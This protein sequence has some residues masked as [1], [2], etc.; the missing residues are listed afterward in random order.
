LALPADREWRQNWE[1]PL[2]AESD[3]ASIN[4][5]EL[6]KSPKSPFSVIP[7]KAGIQFLR[8]LTECLDAG[9]HRGDGFLRSYQL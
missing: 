8:A 9:F 4:L 6:V 7:A 2:A 5:D 1:L 3:P